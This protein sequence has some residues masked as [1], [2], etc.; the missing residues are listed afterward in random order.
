MFCVKLVS[1]Q[2]NDS[3][4]PKIL[5]FAFLLFLSIASFSGSVTFNVKASN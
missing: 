4:M 1:W 2:Y 5:L 3:L